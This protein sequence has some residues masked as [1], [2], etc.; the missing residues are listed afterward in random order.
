VPWPYVSDLFF[1]YF[2]LYNKFRAVDSI[3]AVTGLCF[4]ILALLA[5]NEVIVNENKA[6]LFKKLKIAFYII[7]GISLIIAVLPSLFLSLKP[8]NQLAYIDQLSQMLKIDNATASSF[9]QALVEDRASVAQADALRSLIF[10]ALTFAIAWAFIKKKTNVTVLSVGFLALILADMWTVDKR[11]LNND[12]FVPKQD[13]N[14]PQPREVDQFISKDKDPD[15]RVIDLTQSIKGD[16]ITPFFYKSIGGYSAARLKRFEEVVDEQLTKSINHEVLDMLN[17]KY[18]ISQDPKNQN[19][20]MQVNQTAC[21]HAWFVKSIKYADNADQEMQAISSFD[22]K[23]EVI[24]DK[25]Y[26]SDIDE[27][28]LGNDPAGKIDLVSYNPDHMIYESGSTASQIAVFS[29][30]YYDKGWKMLI[31]GVEKPYFRANYLLRAAQIPVGNHKIE[32]I[33]HPTSY[34]AGENISLAGSILL[35]LALGGAIYTETKKKPAVKP[36]AKKA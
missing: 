36:A 32:F 9:A 1:N 22:P 4:P 8:S 25:Q 26:K 13:N 15:F 30:I 33:F 17:T 7:G 20:G 5:V 27:K 28:S 35:V 2:P 12:S 19:L 31:D 23:N 6:D 10:V 21:G 18:I 16:G 29:E 34:Y 14:T 3:L 24:I 11:Y